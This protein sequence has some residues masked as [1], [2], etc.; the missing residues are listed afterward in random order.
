MSHSNQ[1]VLKGIQHLDEQMQP[2][3]KEFMLLAKERELNVILFETFRTKARQAWLYKTGASKAS[4]GRGMHEFGL[5]FDV[6]FDDPKPWGENHPWSELGQISKDLGLIWG[7]NFHSFLDRPHH[8]LVRAE[9]SEQ[10][11]AREGNLPTPYPETLKLG[12]WGNTVKIMQ[13]LIND[14][15]FTFLKVDGSL[16]PISVKAIKQI[17]LHK[18]LTEDGI[19]RGGT[20]KALI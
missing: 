10:R 9:R 19:C 4:P 12:S 20:W 17:Q 18:G 7:G 6:V 5:A 15:N 11:K 13:T 8:Q 2:F 14:K 3:A 1:S 16:G